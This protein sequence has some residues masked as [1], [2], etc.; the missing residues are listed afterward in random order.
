MVHHDL[1]PANILLNTRGQAVLTDF[2]IA[3]IVGGSTQTL[4]GIEA[5]ETRL[6]GGGPYNNWDPLWVKRK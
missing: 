1:K 4:T 6:V 2:G 5:G 3:K